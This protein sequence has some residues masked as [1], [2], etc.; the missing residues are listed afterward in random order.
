MTIAALVTVA[1]VALAWLFSTLHYALADLSMVKLQEIVERRGGR[2]AIDHILEDLDG[3]IL[4]TGALRVLCNSTI[5]VCAVVIFGAF[6]ASGG[7]TGGAGPSVSLLMLG[8]AVVAS[9]AVILIFALV[10]PMSL[11]THAGERIVHACRGVLAGVHLLA[12]P[13]RTMAI[14]DI[15]VKRLAGVAH[16]SEAEEMADEILSAVHEGQREGNIG[17]AER[18]MIEAVVDFKSRTVEE[19]MTPRT[20]MEGIELTD[21][22]DFIRDFISRAGHSR[23]PVYI[24]DLDHIVGILYA[25]DLLKYLGR[26]ARDFRLRPIL[27]RPVWVP[28]TKPLRELLRELRA[29]KVHLAIV[30]DEY[31]GTTGL[32]TFE[33]LLEEIVGEIQDEYEMHEEA[34][35][36]VTVDPESRSAEIDA[37]AYISDANDD[38]SA[39]GIALPDS[40]E[41]DTVGGFVLASLGRIPVAHESFPGPGFVITVLEA[42]PTRV[43]RVRV[44]ARSEAQAAAD[45]DPP[46]QADAEPQPVRAADDRAGK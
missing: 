3:H 16:I 25:K 2:R 38:L 9:S 6:R 31:G 35:P 20:E 43:V 15:P 19:I 22:L 7:G 28:E 42:E 45:A 21:N 40:E 44:E 30:L 1:A 41:Y 36:E 13:L 39:I 17:D 34:E 33:D 29:R 4:A 23:I 14:I 46:P 5:A 8:L 11:A 27:R 10:I 26:D 32:V 37:R 24:G 18:E 12:S